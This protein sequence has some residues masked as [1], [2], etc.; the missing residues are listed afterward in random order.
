MTA[1]HGTDGR[2][3]NTET[4]RILLPLNNFWLA[5]GTP[6]AA[7]ADGASST[8]GLALADSEAAGVRWNN[9]ATPSAIWTQVLLPADRKPGTDIVLNVLAS[10]SGATSGDAV[11]FTVTAFAPAV[12][13]LHDADANLG[14]ASSAM[15]GAAT[16]K[17]VQ[18][19]TLALASAD[20]PASPAAMA[21]SIKPTDGT[22]G[23]DDVVIEAIWLEY[24]RKLTPA[25]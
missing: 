1:Y 7:F 23:T 11:T 6:L 5:A 10:K 21:L 16:A 13:A 8:P 24:E 3:V 14:G 17:T 15:S 2:F 22:L 12:G 4:G 25:G 20:I 18:R 9:A 19:C